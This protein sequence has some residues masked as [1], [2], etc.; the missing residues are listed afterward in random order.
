VARGLGK[1]DIAYKYFRRANNEAVFLTPLLYNYIGKPWKSAERIR[2]IIAESYHTGIEGLPGNED[3]VSMSVWY[4]FHTIGFYP[5]TEADSGI[6]TSQTGLISN[7]LWGPGP[8][9]GQPVA[10]FHLP[11]QDVTELLD[12][13]RIKVRSKVL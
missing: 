12:S 1:N 10:N 6:S 9:H 5:A 8:R 2:H 13:F 4:I 7:L 11:C 3:S